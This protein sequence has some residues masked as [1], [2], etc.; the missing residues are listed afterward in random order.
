MR[1]LMLGSGFQGDVGGP[2][3]P[4]YRCFKRTVRRADVAMRQQAFAEIVRLSVDGGD[5][6]PP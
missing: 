6:V 5:A 3:A 2:T 4:D 1:G